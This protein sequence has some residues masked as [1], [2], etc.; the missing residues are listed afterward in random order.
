MT[1]TKPTTIT[2]TYRIV[3]PMFCSGADQ[4]KAE[5]RLP[6]FKG[7]LRF[8]WRSLMWGKVPNVQDLQ[9][10]EAALFGA[11]D[12]KVG[13]S[14]VRLRISNALPE[15][16]TDAGEILEGG[17]LLGLHYLGYGVMEAFNGKNTKAGRLTRPMLPGGQFTVSCRFSRFAEPDQIEEVRRAL[18]LLGTV[19]GVGSKSRK[20]FGSLTLTSLAMNDEQQ[21]LPHSIQE[22][23]ATVLYERRDGL[24]DWTAWSSNSRLVVT[25]PESGCRAVDVLDALGREEVHFRSWGRNGTVLRQPSEQNFQVDHDLSKGLTTKSE[26]PFRVAFGLPHNYGKGAQNEVAPENGDRRASPLF[27]HV[28]HPN[29]DVTPSGV[30]VFLPAG[31]L[32]DRERVRAFGRS[33]NLDATESFWFPVHAFLDRLDSDGTRPKSRPGY[34]HFPDGS[35]WWQKKT[36]LIGK[37]VSLG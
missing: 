20:G 18:V 22:R 32:P 2:A 14:I 9:Q 5:L 21:E 3:T 25:T 35:G 4:Q 26:Y 30:A 24:P 31:F 7:A 1:Q 17:R 27:L 29:N 28:H 13:Q 33:V 34:E 37:D 12:Q 8:W 10:K 6:S 19:G 36:T 11:S 15:P 16:Q 23:L